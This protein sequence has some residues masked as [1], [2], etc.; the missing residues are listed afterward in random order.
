MF[1]WF[2]NKLF[3]FLKK[4]GQK[5]K[6]E[7]NKNKY[8]ILHDPHVTQFAKFV[9]KDLWN[10]FLSVNLIVQSFCHD[11]R[12]LNNSLTVELELGKQMDEH[13]PQSQFF[14]FYFLVWWP[15]SFIHIY[16][17]NFTQER[18]CDESEFIKLTW[19]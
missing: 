6:A 9:K 12:K 17:T 10:I 15:N 4:R 16:F 14:L 11:G 5:Q 3:S 13:S 1:V 7:I 8:K 18:E 19:K 2:T